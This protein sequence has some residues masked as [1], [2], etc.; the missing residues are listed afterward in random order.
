MTNVLS[1]TEV[2]F[3]FPASEFILKMK[4]KMEFFSKE[5]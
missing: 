1:V 2:L 5:L 3:L 4:T